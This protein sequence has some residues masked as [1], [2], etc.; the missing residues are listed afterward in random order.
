M[1]VFRPHSINSNEAIQAQ[2]SQQVSHEK[3]VLDSLSQSYTNSENMARDKS[4]ELTKS[5]A[6]GKAHLQGASE[7]QNKDLQKSAQE[8]LSANERIAKQ[9]SVSENV[10][11]RHSVS[12]GL[13]IWGT[14]ATTSGSSEAV[15]QDMR[16]F[17]KDT[18]INRDIAERMSQGLN[19]A[20]T[21]QVNFSEDSSK[22]TAESYRSSVTSAQNFNDQMSIQK[23]KV[24]R[25]QEMGSLMESQGINITPNL[26]DDVL[27][28][29]AA[30]N[31]WSKEEAGR[32]SSNHSAAFR[33]EANSYIQGWTQ[34]MSSWL[35]SKS[36]P[37][38]SSSIDTL[39]Q[40]YKKDIT[41]NK[42]SMT[43]SSRSIREKATQEGIGFDRAEASEQG[44]TD[45]YEKT[46]G[47]VQQSGPNLGE[48]EEMLSGT[49]NDLER[50][51]QGFEHEFDKFKEKN[52]TRR[53]GK[54]AWEKVS[55]RLN[56][57]D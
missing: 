18:G 34:N 21:N 37:L 19:A 43:D 47:Y 52:V 31:N 24:D 27:E 4:F 57:E 3:Q 38:D 25:F 56:K 28:Y 46:S 7:S 16:Q 53:A 23:S 33:E 48:I 1:E 29:I 36:G 6:Q 20:L 30:K 45:L 41:T 35:E 50:T 51:H 44:M 14:G 42:N 55:S 17:T 22:R 39:Y 40:T 15:N 54:V 5:F 12:G 10:A 8:I 11:W 49:E 9:Q 13:K 26:N 32:W 2:V